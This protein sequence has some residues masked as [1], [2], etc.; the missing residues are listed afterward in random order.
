MF[1]DAVPI[2]IGMDA[3]IIGS[4]A[5]VLLGWLK[6]RMITAPFT[7]LALVLVATGEFLRVIETD[8]LR[9]ELRRESDT[10][11]RVL[12]EDIMAIREA[13]GTVDLAELAS[14]AQRGDVRIYSLALVDSDGRTI[15]RWVSDA[16]VQHD[17]V[18]YFTVP[19]RVLVRRAPEL[20]DL[21]NQ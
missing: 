21:W 20:P 7:K 10:A 1:P 19:T 5:A 13:N 14:T 12:S 4:F 11:A 9:D 18:I 2:S 16:S 15:S 17:K 3:I 8:Y 6:W